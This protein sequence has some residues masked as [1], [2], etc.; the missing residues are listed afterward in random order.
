[1][2]TGAGT[3][4]DPMDA[5]KARV[6]DVRRRLRRA[7]RDCTDRRRR[8]V[9]PLSL[10]SR[11]AQLT[12]CSCKLPSLSYPCSTTTSAPLTTRCVHRRR[13]PLRTLAL[14]GLPL[15]L[16]VTQLYSPDL[17]HASAPPSPRSSPPR[18]R[19]TSGASTST[20]A[21]GARARST[22]PRRRRRCVA[23]RG[24]PSSLD[25]TPAVAIDRV[26]C[27]C[28]R[29]KAGRAW[30]TRRGDAGVGSI[31]PVFLHLRAC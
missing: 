25:V 27:R 31:S 8:L 22:S 13:K 9:A 4:T 3:S 19:R 21:S 5:L 17:N 26:K 12:H 14:A 28:L 7:L 10:F 29:V 16:R 2:A 11:A 15:T 6:K 23:A 24:S 18:A 1:M 30:R 20:T